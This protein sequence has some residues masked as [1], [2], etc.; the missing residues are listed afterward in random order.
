LHPIGLDLTQHSLLWATKGNGHRLCKKI[1]RSFKKALPPK[2]LDNH[3]FMGLINDCAKFE[4]ARLL[5]EEG[6]RLLQTPG[7]S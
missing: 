5:R 2:K 3:V 1:L 6:S 4:D 7:Q